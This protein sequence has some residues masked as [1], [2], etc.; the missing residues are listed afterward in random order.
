MLLRRR[1]QVYGMTRP[2]RHDLKGA[3]LSRG[4]LTDAE[5]RILNPLLPARGERGRNALVVPALSPR[6]VRL[7]GP[8]DSPS[9]FVSREPRTK[10]IGPPFNLEAHS[11]ASLRRRNVSLTY[12]SFPP[13]LDSPG[14]RFELRES[15][16]TVCAPRALSRRT[17]AKWV[18]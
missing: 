9:V 17:A 18:A 5:W 2:S 11:S 15:R 6:I 16:Q 1:E 14:T 13:H 12:F 7:V 3:A 8:R 4:D 10:A